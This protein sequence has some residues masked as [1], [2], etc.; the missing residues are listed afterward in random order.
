MYLFAG[1]GAPSE[2]VLTPILT[3]TSPVERYGSAVTLVDVSTDFLADLAIGSPGANEVV[4]HRGVVT[5]E[6]DS[7]LTGPPG[8]DFGA[9]FAD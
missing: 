9:I 5:T 6:G 8:S 1:A 7:V 3:L 4:V 2:L